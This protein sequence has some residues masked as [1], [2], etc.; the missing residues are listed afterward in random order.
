MKYPLDELTEI[1]EKAGKELTEKCSGIVES[2]IK[3]M[4]IHYRKQG[5]TQ[6]YILDDLLHHNLSNILIRLEY[7][8]MLKW[9]EVSQIDE[10]LT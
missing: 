5:I 8:A 9:E 1:T 7:E 3:E 10:T 2:L 6:Q 4:D